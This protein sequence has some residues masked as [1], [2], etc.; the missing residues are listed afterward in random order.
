MQE[1]SQKKKIP[2]L[3]GR[4]GGRRERI[5]SETNEPDGQS[6]RSTDSCCAAN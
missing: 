3:Y 5:H 6:D 1:I 2:L 4:E